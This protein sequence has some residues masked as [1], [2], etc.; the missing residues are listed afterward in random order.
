MPHAF[1]TVMTRMTSSNDDNE[2]KTKYHHDLFLLGDVLQ[3]HPATYYHCEPLEDFGIKQVRYGDTA[4]QALRNLRHLL[5]C[6]YSDMGKY[7]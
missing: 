1:N 2:M 4:K 6:D 5:T 7:C 3:I